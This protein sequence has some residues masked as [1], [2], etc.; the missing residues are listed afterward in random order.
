MKKIRLF[1]LKMKNF[2]GI[3]EM[4]LNFEGEG[5][6]LAG[7]NETGKTTIADAFRW[8]LFDKDSQGN[9][10]FEIKP[11]DDK[12][13][14]IH[15]LHSIVEARI[16]VIDDKADKR[17]KEFWLK[18][19]YHEVWQK[20]RG[21][22][23]KVFKG[24]TTDYY[25]DEAPC[26]KSEYEGFISE[27]I[28]DEELFKLLTEPLY[29]NE[30]LHWEEQRELLFELVDKPD[31]SEVARQ[32][33]TYYLV[34]KL[35]DK[36]VST[37]TRVV[38]SK[39]TKLDKK[40]QE[41]PTRIDEIQKS[42]SADGLDFDTTR[43]GLEKKIEEL[44][45]EKDKLEKKSLAGG[46]DIKEKLIKLRKEKSNLEDR[47]KAKAN[48]QINDIKNEISKL[49]REIADAKSE[50]KN[51]NERQNILKERRS[52]LLAKYHEEEAKEFTG[53]TCPYCKQKLPEDKLEEHKEE[54]KLEKSNTLE[55][56]KKKGVAAARE[57]DEID[58]SKEKLNE[59]IKEVKELVA[60]YEKKLEKGKAFLED[61][62]Q[63]QYDK[64]AEKQAKIDELEEKLEEGDNKDNAEKIWELKKEIAKE[65][66]KL[67][68]M[69]NIEKARKRIEQL[70]EK[71]QSMVEKYE[72]LEKELYDIE[73]FRRVQIKMIEDDINALFEQTEVKLFEEQVNGELK[74]TC[75]TMKNGVPYS[76]LN[77][78]SKYQVGMEIIKTLME[79]KQAKAPI[80][81]DNRE[82]IAVLP[83]LDTQTIH[84]V[85]TPG[86][87]KIERFGN[88]VEDKDKIDEIMNESGLQET[89]F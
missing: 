62:E 26:K 17:V 29:F 42:L 30:Q 87:K 21:K 79:H 44:R 27:N 52:N 70:Q 61:L 56:I 38:K 74:E 41:I 12:N 53:D 51:K 66:K 68:N 73:K 55:N 85:M 4:E 88:A 43:K 39:M 82:R 20:K 31:N 18:K 8:L 37:H 25:I 10:R 63:G 49:K 15:H 6:Y 80:F 7:T 16:Q 75:E 45:A 32:A 50:L 54:F 24:H 58:K 81:I 11:L 13:E 83:R 40:I 1:D 71:E 46:A 69:E 23:E 60:E 2:K 57:I 78:G 22:S 65:E 47:L 28:L 84:L 3:E 9:S 89:L 19:D 34:E 86:R 77:T 14:P 35:E 33:E 72:A 64:V 59:R 76:A 5:C 67:A 36:D 48:E